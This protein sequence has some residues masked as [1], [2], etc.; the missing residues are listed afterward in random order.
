MDETSGLDEEVSAGSRRPPGLIGAVD[1]VLRLLS[2]FQKHEI[3]R[4]NQVAREMELSRSTVHRMLATLAH[5]GYVEQDELSRGYRPG[6]ALVD[7]GLAV[8]RSIDIRSAAQITLMRLRDLTNESVHLAVLRGSQALFLDSVES[9]Q[10]LRTGSRIGWTLPAH[11]TASGKVLLA[12]LPEDELAGLYPAGRLE[13]VTAHTVTTLEELRAQLAEVRKVGYAVNNAESEVDVSAVALAV[14][15][16][17]GSPR[18]AIAITAPLSRAGGSWAAR[19]AEVARPVI[20]DLEK[21]IG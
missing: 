21:Q 19:T 4:V 15:P 14:R 8:F 5:H 12:A 7:L 18:V 16:R 13:A 3:L 20:D 9:R 17:T 10:M 1:N 6:P 11:A 2:L